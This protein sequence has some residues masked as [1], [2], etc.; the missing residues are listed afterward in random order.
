MMI[1]K[2]RRTLAL[3]SA[4]AGAGLVLGPVCGGAAAMP[5]GVASM[6]EAA[7]CGS[8]PTTTI[9][10]VQGEGDVSPM[11]GKTVTV[12]G[13]VVGDLQ[14]G[15]YNGY[16]IQDAKGD[17]KASTSDGVFVYDPAG[18][19]THV[20]VAVGDVV[21]VE[22]VVNEYKGLTQ[23]SSVK[24]NTV[25]G[26]QELPAAATLDLPAT[27]AQ[28]E[29]LEGMYIRPS[30]ALTVTDVYN[31]NRFGEVVLSE[32][33]V[34]KNPTEV[35]QP[36]KAAQAVMKQNRQRRIILDDGRSGNLAKDKQQPPYLTVKDPVRVGD[37]VS[38]LQPSVLSYGFDAY[39]L[40]PADGTWE[41]TTF[42][43]KSPRT[44]AP[45]PVAGNLKIADAN[46]LNYFVTFGDKSRG[47]DN[48]EEQKR[49]EAKIIAELRALN[50]DVIALQE[51]EN[52]AVTTPSDPYK[53]LRT[54]TEALNKAEGAQ[55]WGFVE[56]HEA[57]DLITTAIIYRRDRVEP[58][59]A[60]MKPAEN[61]VWDNAR[62]PIAQAFSAK[63]EVF[64][65]I[66]NHFKSKGSGQGKGNVDSGDGQG[67]SNADR[68][69]QAKSL[70]AFVKEVKAKTKDA[71]VVSVG[72]YN[73]YTKEQPLGV[74]RKAG[75]VDL[76]AK[77]AA[78]DTYV[79]NG[80]SG[81]LDHAF[82]T[83]EFAEKVQDMKVWDINAQESYAYQYN[84]V[85][86]LYAPD[87]FRASDH[88]PMILGVQTGR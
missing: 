69:A 56:A 88:N 71:D 51:V 66:V 6:P 1:Q 18:S 42:A 36:G 44:S 82:A 43:S 50:A 47:A 70:V 26:K 22:G 63:G 78:Q 38:V 15:G 84:G 14:E 4:L 53:A 35:E 49:Q 25:C 57:S 31:L 19:A 33:G 21:V 58:V 45:A 59:G 60:A 74:L 20:N 65:L 54:L 11:E 85:P 9:P 12:R 10:Q 24:A 72:D 8:E 7:G 55:V 46:V 27:P 61:S 29:A 16:F 32:G 81:S 52:S 64:S 40:E 13:V 2:N 48:A 3:L 83:P 73:A 87:A 41:E 5:L 39:R 68:V 23:I 37:Q 79:F 67:N 62:E 86:A 76:G 77:F 75:L 80:E 17:G 30:D 28:L 34:L